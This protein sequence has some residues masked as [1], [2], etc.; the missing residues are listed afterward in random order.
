MTNVNKE[1]TLNKRVLKYISMYTYETKFKQEVAPIHRII[2]GHTPRVV[3]YT[4]MN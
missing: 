1:A 2:Y 4:K 3:V